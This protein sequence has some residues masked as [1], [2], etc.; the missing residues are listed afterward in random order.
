MLKQSF[1]SIIAPFQSAKTAP[2]APPPS[3]NLTLP[4]YPNVAYLHHNH[5][6]PRVH[7]PIPAPPAYSP[8]EISEQARAH[9]NTRRLVF[10]LI[11]A[12]LAFTAAVLLV[13]LVSIFVSNRDDDWRAEQHNL[14]TQ[15]NS[16]SRSRDPIQPLAHL[17]HLFP[18]IPHLAH[19]VFGP[20]TIA[21]SAIGAIHKSYKELSKQA[22]KDRPQ[23]RTN[24]F[25]T[26]SG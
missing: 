7:I 6:D 23:P 22:N 2:C 3:P 5:L 9:K 12:T 19:P 26:T 15:I 4:V 14:L 1:L 13:I 17:E 21:S 16:A 20:L 11:A 10:S 25:A 24:S 18:L 8:S